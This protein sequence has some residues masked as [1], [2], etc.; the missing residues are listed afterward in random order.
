[1]ALVIRNEN[2]LH[3]A[4]LVKEELKRRLERYAAAGDCLSARPLVSVIEDAEAVFLDIYRSLPTNERTLL[5]RF[6]EGSAIDAPFNVE[7]RLTHFL[8]ITSAS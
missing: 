7:A 8:H 6:L 4:K 2:E 1:M 5:S 3:F